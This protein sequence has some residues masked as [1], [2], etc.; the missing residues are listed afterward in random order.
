MPMPVKFAILD[1]VLLSFDAIHAKQQH[2]LDE[3]K[4]IRKI[5]LS[6]LATVKV[7]FGFCFHFYGVR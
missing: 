5:Q 6:T 3:E 1:I 2:S 4:N 7:S